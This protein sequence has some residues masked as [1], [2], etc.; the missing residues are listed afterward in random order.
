M[1]NIFYIVTD[2]GKKYLRNGLPEK[3][4]AMLLE[5]GPSDMTTAKKKI[6]NFEIALQ[7]CKKKGLVEIKNGILTLLKKSEFPEE[8]AL[9]DV[10]KCKNIH[11]DIADLLLS[12]KLI[13]IP[14]ET[15]QKRAEK[16]IGKDISNLTEELIKTGLW[17]DVKLK[18][19]NVE[20]S[21]KKLH[22]GKRQPYNHFL[23]EV[24]RKLIEMGFIEMTGPTVELEF[25]NFDALFQAQNHPSRDWTQTYSLK[26]PQYGDLP[27]KK[28]VENVKVAHENGGKTGS[29]G[30]RYTWDPR[31]AA[32]LMPR[33]HDT[34][35]SPRYLSKGVEI[36]GKYFS[37]V[38][39]YRPDVIDATHGVEFNQM[40]GFVIA[41]DLNFK[42]LLGLLRDFA[43][44]FTGVKEIRFY[45]DYYPFTEPS[46]QVS[47]K[48]PVLGWVELAGAG[49][50]REELTK[51][52]GI[53]VPVIAWGFGIDRIAMYKLKINDIR[54]LFSQNLDW[55]RNAVVL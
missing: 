13:E 49:I 19:Y 20:V 3:N 37:I 28:T 15:L 39:C 8:R 42:D 5:K 48:H 38:R 34:A 16:L 23:L 4:L 50:F 25:W 2:E 24:R 12:R 11:K 36:P 10:E 53:D 47:A 26:H 51:P 44:E 46:V 35:I 29:T 22:I 52:L 33:A 45:A 21:G 18:P 55:L 7:W 31:K 43:V 14:R 30:W 17:K 6:E 32:K 41:D 1:N 54:S 27:D 9:K 40:G